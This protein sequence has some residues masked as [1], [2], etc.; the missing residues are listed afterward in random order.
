MSDR[1]ERRPPDH[2]G[3]DIWRAFK[4]FEAAMYADL[5]AEGF[6]D[7]S[8]ADSDV[9][10]LIGPKGTRM[11]ALAAA[12]RITK[13]AAHEQVRS[14]LAR[15]YLELG[16]DPTDGRAKIVRLTDQGDA[17]VKVLDAAKMDLH[18][19]VTARIGTHGMAQLKAL[20][21]DVETLLR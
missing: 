10:V 12:R 8:V 5:D 3:A 4:A 6:A 1:P 11:T 2:I 16:P 14:L 7:I 19:R 15:G 21:A 9:L 20:L 17:L 18:A 13:Q